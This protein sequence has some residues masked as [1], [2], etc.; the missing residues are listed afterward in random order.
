[1]KILTFFAFF[2]AP[3]H[4]LVDV[5]DSMPNGCGCGIDPINIVYQMARKGIILYSVGCEPAI[6]S[7]K[8]F[9]VSIAYTTGGQYVPLTDANSLARII[10]GGAQEEI[11]LEKLIGNVEYEIEELL[12]YGANDKNDI[13]EIIHRKLVSEGAF[14][15]TLKHNNASMEAPSV[16]AVKYSAIE[17]LSDLK[18]E[19]SK[20]VFY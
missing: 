1:L 3:P 5:G 19:F 15:K 12:K 2:K 14:I 18:N 4:G 13:T 8:D 16:N 20:F 6:L 17:S 11:S 7:Y 9:F 10:I